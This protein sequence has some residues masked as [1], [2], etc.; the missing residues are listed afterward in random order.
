M[1]TKADDDHFVVITDGQ[2]LMNL[3]L[4]WRDEVP[5]DWEPIAPDK[6]R[7]IACEI[8][9][10]FGTGATEAIS[11]QSVA[12][13]GYSAVVV[14]DLL[15]N[16]T[17]NPPS[18]SPLAAAAQNLVSAL[19]GGIPEKAPFGLERID[20]DPETRTCS[21]VWANSEISVPNGIPSISE[22]SGLVYGAGQRDGQWGLEGLDFATGE[23]R[24]WVAAGPGTCSQENAGLVA[25]LPGVADV[26]AQVPDSCENSVYAATTIGPDGMVYQGTLNGM[27]RYV[28]EVA[29]ALP[30]AS[31]AAA[32]VDQALDLLARSESDAPSNISERNYLRRAGVQLVA[33]EAV[34]LGA[35]LDDIATAAA[36]ALGSVDAAIA[37]LDAGEPYDAHVQDAR[38]ALSAL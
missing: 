6:D 34:A 14:N 12:V 17:I 16:P 27:T 30:A 15:T 13:R 31:Q 32:G 20:W 28:P 19:E 25:L 3:V 38:E 18:M 10:D 35:G 22:A 5:E 8:A 33:T 1:G 4:F 21:T 11:E 26:L 24:V 36:T 23:S 37:A 29:Q 9:V 7:R 2:A